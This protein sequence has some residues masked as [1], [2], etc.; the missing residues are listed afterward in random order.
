V[1][2]KN[3]YTGKMLMARLAPCWVTAMV[4]PQLVGPERWQL[5]AVDRFTK[6]FNTEA[7]IEHI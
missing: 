6:A 7:V 4:L 2:V 3:G 5:D 1:I